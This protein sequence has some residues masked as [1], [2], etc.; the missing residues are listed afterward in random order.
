[1]G[2]EFLEPNH[3]QQNWRKKSA[4]IY[5]ILQVYEEGTVS[6]TQVFVWVKQF[7][8]GIEDILDN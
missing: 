1:M 6:K 4:N 2:D 3:F 8:D 7:P 5:K